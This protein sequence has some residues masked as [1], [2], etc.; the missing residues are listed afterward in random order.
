[1]N[2]QFLFYLMFPLTIIIS[3]CFQVPTKQNDSPADSDLV[4]TGHRGYAGKYPENTLIGIQKALELGVDRIEI[5]VHQ[6]KDE[7]L[8]L[9]HDTSLDRTTNGEGKIKDLYYKDLQTLNAS[10]EFS[11]DFAAE[12]IPTLKEALAMVQG[13]AQLI[14][15]IKEGHDYY[16]NIEKHILQT[17]AD[18][19]AKDWCIIHSFK[20]EVLEKVHEL[21]TTIV[22]HKLLLSPIFYDFEKLD[23][24]S[25]FSI[26]HRFISR[27]LIDKIHKLGKKVNTWTVND[28]AKMQK[29]KDLGIDGI[30]TDFPDLAVELK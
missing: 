7:V 12:K 4:I 28:A 8:I 15:E 9:M 5:D 13:K 25:E 21:D 17:I 11:P 2:K 24:V 19:K 16:P 6:T 23:Y 29:L 3:Y 18:G 22:L 14:I 10:A 30:I 27:S 26:Y 20:N 1:M